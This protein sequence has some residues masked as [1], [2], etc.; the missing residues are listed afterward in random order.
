VCTLCIPDAQ[1][2]PSSRHRASAFPLPNEQDHEGP[3][4]PCHL[5]WRP[6]LCGAIALGAL[7]ISSVANTQA[8]AGE[9]P[10]VQ[11]AAG[12]F[13]RFMAEAAKRFEIPAPWI[14][15]VMRV[16]SAGDVHAISPKGAMG[17]MQI[18]PETWARLRRRYG[19]G[20]D[21]CDPHDNITAGA[22]YLRE[23][24]DRYG[25]P[26]FLAAYNAGPA[27]YEDHLTTGR[28]LPAETR[29][30]VAE[31]GRLLGVDTLDNTMLAVVVAHART[32]APLF[33]T[34]S[35]SG[36]QPLQLSSAAPIDQPLRV[37]IAADETDLA[38]NSDG[39]FVAISH[40]KAQP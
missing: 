13:A 7:F 19:L 15:S 5:R 30:Y 24:Y 1:E 31:V 21:P 18:R 2:A 9:P 4:T 14:R 36:A 10:I 37:T 17:L 22:A 3:V 8:I 39:L 11:A 25:A 33:P 38:P 12:P 20:A 26:G 40:R 35:N 6:L 28:P 23:L 16:E 34:R 32:E 27:R 29:A